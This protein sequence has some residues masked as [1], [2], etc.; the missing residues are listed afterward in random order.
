MSSSPAMLEQCEIL[1][2]QSLCKMFAQ[3]LREAPEHTDLPARALRDKGRAGELPAEA[4]PVLVT[5]LMGSEHPLVIADLAKALASF[6]RHGAMGS[7]ILIEKLKGFII[8]D[9]PEFWALD[10]CLYA[11]GYMGGEAALP[12]I[13]EQ[14]EAFTEARAA[15][16]S[17]RP[18]INLDDYDD[19]DEL[20]D[21]Y[22][23][24][25]VKRST[26]TWVT[27]VGDL[28][29]GDMPAGERDATFAE[30]LATVRDM[31]EKEDAG[32]WSSRLGEFT[33]EESKPAKK[34]PAWLA[35]V[36]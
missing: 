36:S 9:D 28:Y 24:E 16:E 31:L 14:I 5:C 7:A 12:Y 13:E 34:L 3:L 30:T 4:I 32:T 33:A 2:W 22:V 26:G 25:V 17:S 23:Y 19:A 20:D 35:S 18:E 1:D 27:R 10:G 11:L 29:K 15:Y 21:G 8:S 6:G